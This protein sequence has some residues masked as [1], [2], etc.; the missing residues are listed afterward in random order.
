MAKKPRVAIIGRVNV[1]KSTLFNTLTSGATA[2]VSK[3]AGTTRDRKEGDCFWLGKVFTII[4]T[5]GLDHASRSKIEKEI[6]KQAQ[7]ALKNANLILFVVDVKDGITPSD[8]AIARELSK[9]KKKP[10]LLV[11]NKADSAKD[12]PAVADFYKLGFD[13]PW[14]VSAASGIGTGDLL[15]DIAR[16]IPSSVTD[17]ES[18]IKI[19]IIGKPNVGK[20]SLLNAVLGE[21]RAIVDDKPYTTRDSNALRTKFEGH[22]FELIDTAG[23]RRKS[24]V[25]K[26]SIEL[27][28]V[29]Q[30]LESITAADVVLLVTEAHTPLTAQD[31][32]LAN[33]IGDSR[34]AV[35]IIG[36]KWD[37]VDKE[38][39]KVA[40][41][42]MEYY[43]RT[44]NFLSWAPILLLS[45][46]E[47][48][49]VTRLKKTIIAVYHEKFRNIN[50]N[51]LNK[52]L[53][54]LIKHRPPTKGKGTARPY[55]YRLKQVGV[56]PP[57]FAVHIKENTYLN[58]S[59][60]NFIEKQ[61]RQKFGFD[62]SPIKLWIE[63]HKQ[64]KK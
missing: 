51:A 55:I 7:H 40:A 38:D 4:D 44:L 62:G 32:Q 14:A 45:A 17:T 9:D 26:K 47:K 29:Q 33:L 37:I 13:K 10:I 28:S 11:A 42:Y 46:L 36:N 43:R 61:L 31:K 39:S 25:N 57:Q 22:I 27:K 52:F 20:S 8:R 23:V 16:Q 2:L 15:D 54:S 48:T 1:G 64:E 21:E 50:D 49:Q 59:Y 34:A 56:N 6:T 53:K 3:I 30:S 63:Q 12:I 35:I 5:G 19:A 60:L 18:A 58:Y 41:K 24:K